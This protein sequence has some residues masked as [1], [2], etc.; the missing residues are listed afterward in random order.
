MLPFPCNYALRSTQH[1]KYVSAYKY[2][3]SVCFFFFFVRKTIK[4]LVCDKRNLY[5]L[6]FVRAVARARSYTT[7]LMKENVTHRG[8]CTLFIKWWINTSSFP[9]CINATNANTR[10]QASSAP[11]AR[12]P[13]SVLI[14]MQAQ[15]RCRRAYQKVTSPYP[16]RALLIKIILRI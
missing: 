7:Q 4:S 9:L 12:K 11:P 8:S 13:P 2:F 16:L 15:I 3:N 14:S 5:I 1:I 6:Y 10:A